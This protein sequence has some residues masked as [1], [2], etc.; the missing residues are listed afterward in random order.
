[1]K[2]SC[3]VLQEALCASLSG[4]LSKQ[5]EALTPRSMIDWRFF[6]QPFDVTTINSLT[7]RPHSVK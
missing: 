7:A 3:L 6:Q 4:Q 2:L 1:M 5:G